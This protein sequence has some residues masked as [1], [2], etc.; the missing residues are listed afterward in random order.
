MEERGEPASA[1]GG[2]SGPGPG[3][4]HRGGR[5][6]CGGA[7]AGF[8]GVAAGGPRR[9][10]SERSGEWEALDPTL[11]VE[12]RYDQF[13]GGRFRHGTK[14]LRWRPNKKPE[15]CTMD[16]VKGGGVSVKLLQLGKK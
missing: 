10:S 15:A 14:F 2:A 12:L 5:E 8:G 1:G 9:W 4:Q 16:Q 6:R 7:E 3:G 11:V 13:S